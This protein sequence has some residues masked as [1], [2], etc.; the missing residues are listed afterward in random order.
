MIDYLR[1]KVVSKKDRKVVLD[2]GGFGFTL[3]SLS[4][5]LSLVKEGEE[6]L[7]YVYLNY[8]G[9]VLE[10][11]GFLEENDRDFFEKLV[12]LTKIGT[13]VSFEVLE[14]FS[15]KEFIEI[16]E[17][18]D[19]SLLSSIPKVGEKRAKR[20]I[21]ELK[22]KLLSEEGAFSEVKEALLSLGYTEREANMALLRVA[23]DGVK[24]KSV[25]ALLKEAL[26]VLKGDG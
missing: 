3:F 14:R 12:G 5:D 21:F 25:E 18:E 16:I 7:F 24:G 20:I 11:F 10:L 2:V 19:L 23:K 26:A 13:R 6:A 1:G 8:K 22:G 4:R 9:E 17:S 15:W